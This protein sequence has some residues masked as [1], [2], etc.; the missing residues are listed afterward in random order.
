LI[1]V[2]KQTLF[3]E[4]LA[5]WVDDNG[6]TFKNTGIQ[7]GLLTNW[8]I[9]KNGEVRKISGESAVFVGWVDGD[10]S[11]Y[12]EYGRPYGTA[13]RGVFIARGFTPSRIFWVSPDGAI[14]G[15]WLFWARIIA[16]AEGTSDRQCIGA[17]ALVLLRY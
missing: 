8:S 12:D 17:L 15:R 3:G 14:Y 2:Y 6:N 10:G 11:V 4:K 16:R 7:G 5:G 13:P 9:N 1:R